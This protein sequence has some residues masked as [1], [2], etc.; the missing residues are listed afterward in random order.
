MRP[1]DMTGTVVGYDPGGNGKHGLALATVRKGK[2]DRLITKTCGTVEDVLVAILEKPLLGLG[3]DTLTCWSTGHSGLRPADRWLRCR[4]RD[5][6]KAVVAPNSLRGAMSVNGM[7]VLLAVRQAFPNICV[8][9]THPKVLYYARFKE[10]YNYEGPN[11][12][13][14]N[15][16]LNRLLGVDLAPENEPRNEHEW[17]AAISILAVVH[18]IDGSWPNDLHARPADPGE[19][20]VHPCGKTAYVWPEWNGVPD[21]RGCGCTITT[22][23]M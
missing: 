18:G 10:P 1:S 4:Y 11:A 22:T 5:V 7:A 21:D 16:R 19:R 20:L 13:V 8:T 15:E 2:I 3:I 17:D 23:Q 6:K 14:M 12:S 9:E